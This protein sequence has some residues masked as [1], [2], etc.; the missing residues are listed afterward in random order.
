MM[1]TSQTGP[2]ATRGTTENCFTQARTQKACADNLL[3]MFSAIAMTGCQLAGIGSCLRGKIVKLY[4]ER[5]L[6][7]PVME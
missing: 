3:F 2:M 1:L 6:P 4:P 7:L 5:F